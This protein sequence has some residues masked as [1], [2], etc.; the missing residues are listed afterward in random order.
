MSEIVQQDESLK[1]SE[2]GVRQQTALYVSA[3]FDE[4]VRWGVREVVVSPGSRSTALA[5]VAFELSRRAPG[6]LRVYVDVDERGASFFALG[7]AKA[8]GR[9]VCLVCTSGTA[10]A[11]YYPAVMEAETSRVP[12]IVLSG[13]R[14]LRLQGLGAPQTV[15]QMKAYGDH[16][17]AFRQM[18]LPGAD[19]RDIAFAR[20]AAREACLA[21]LG[22]GASLRGAGDGRDAAAPVVIASRGCRY[23]AGPVQVNFQLDEPLTPDFSVDG[24]F[25]RG[26]TGVG[27]LQDYGDSVASAC[28][29]SHEVMGMFHVKHSQCESVGNEVAGG[30]ICGKGAR[31]EGSKGAGGVEGA[32]SAESSQNA[33]SVEDDCRRR[34]FAEASS[35]Y[36]V[37][38]IRQVIDEAFAARLRDVLRAR[39]V[40]VLAGEGTCETA[41]EAREVIAWARRCGA[42]L[43]ADLLSGLRSFDDEVIVDNY[44]NVFGLE[45]CPLPDVVIRFGRYPISKR[46]A[47]RLAAAR[48][49]SVVVDVAETRDFNMSTDLFVPCT[50][51]DFVRSFGADA[52]SGSLVGADAVAFAVEQSNEHACSTVQ[53]DSALEHVSRETCSGHASGQVL[54]D[55]D[56][57]REWIALNARAR[58]AIEAADNCARRAI[59]T[60]NNRTHRVTEAANNQTR[61]VTETVDAQNVSRET[62]VRPATE[63]LAS[64]NP[65]ADGVG[66]AEDAVTQPAEG[67]FASTNPAPV[68]PAPVSVD[69]APVQPAEGEF[70]QALLRLAPEGSCLFSANSMSVRVLDAVYTKADKRL[71]VL[72]NR[73]QN[74]IDGTVSTALGAAQHYAQATFLTGDF[75]MLHDLNALALQ[76]ELLVHHG[77]SKARS[78][79]IVLLNNNGGGIF[80][81]LPQR[82]E[83]AY[84]ERLFVV[85]QDVRFEFAARAFGVPYRAVATIA[86]FEEAYRELLG[87]P[88]ISLIEVGL[89][90]S[91]TK[92][93]Y[94]AYQAI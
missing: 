31:T 13:D 69:S 62:P 11:N 73:G 29:G 22:P 46:C 6:S 58:S 72:C 9:P 91:G 87:T 56:F 59:E 81:M 8:S 23:M 33:A 20:Q 37:A 41:G 85:P 1:A 49:F 5:M 45:D 2:M 79:V 51:L 3:F 10:L 53:S 63:P 61:C 16:V 54:C 65:S 43:L 19:T 94:A 34:C 74:G 50:P 7:L 71:A 25:S 78:I 24:L 83:D 17:R 60:A 27:E 77:G 82:S 92:E 75:T 67:E 64:D 15:D 52:V 35:V 38:P 12:L 36:S 68:Q 84:F 28:A 57:L 47:Q 14:P 21:A 48:P 89:P 32:E 88:G 90:Y 18:P 76:R 66:F 26:R 40:M 86:E 93:R 44:D 42:P 4:L 80:D 30:D 55:G 70:V 39:R